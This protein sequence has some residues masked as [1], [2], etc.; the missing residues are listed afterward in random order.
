MAPYNNIT[1]YIDIN[2]TT[3]ELYSYHGSLSSHIS[4]VFT[5]WYH[6]HRIP[7][8]LH[9]NGIWVTTR[10]QR[11]SLLRDLC[12][13]GQAINGILTFT[14]GHLLGGATPS[15]AD[16]IDDG[17]WWLVMRLVVVIVVMQWLMMVKIGG[18]SL[19]VS[20]MVDGVDGLSF[21][22]CQRGWSFYTTWP[23]RYPITS[24]AVSNPVGQAE[25]ADRLEDLQIGYQRVT[26]K[27]IGD[28]QSTGL[29]S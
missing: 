14:N 22:L 29:S 12:P 6:N 13:C 21:S 17:W 4:R 26:N 27:Q 3:I 25:P 19:V 20:R 1:S 5:N 16:R 11:P 7:V 18:K 15:Q 10:S 28:Q 8:R 24:G 9:R 2:I 23:T